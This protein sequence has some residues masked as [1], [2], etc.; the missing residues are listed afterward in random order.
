MG[1]KATRFRVGQRVSP[2][3]HLTH[4]YGSITLKDAVS[5]LG[6]LHDGVLR[7]FAV[8]NEQSCVEIP[9]NLSYR[10][11]ATLPCAAVTAWNALYGGP[12]S[13][14]PGD[15]VLT[16]GT[17]GVSIFAL[18]FAKLGG[19]EV[20]STTSDGA[21]A[22]KLKK[23]GVNHVLNYKDDPKWGQT[24]KGLS[25]RAKGADFVIEIG[26]P[27]TI[28]QSSQAV[29]VDG[30]IAVIGR[31]AGRNSE[32]QA[33]PIDTLATV[34]RIMVGSRQLHEEMNRAI[35]VHNIKP[36]ID[37]KCFRFSEVQEAYSYFGE[38]RHFWQSCYRHRISDISPDVTAE[39]S[40]PTLCTAPG[41]VGGERVRTSQ[42]HG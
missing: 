25:H 17:G 10:E 19:A 31:L 26:G 32:A 40:R 4:L 34:R 5:Q 42:L 14:K 39:A 36:V 18:Q 21:K 33:A 3:F 2:I 6:S 15:T 27:N 28:P 8:F 37:G 12:R 24:V 13:L 9:E 7:Q 22:E 30:Q 20:I 1:P 23:M 11:A 16:Q 35:E 38:A 29:C 41:L